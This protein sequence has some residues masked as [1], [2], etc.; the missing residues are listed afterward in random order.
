MLLPFNGLPRAEDN[1]LDHKRQTKEQAP[2]PEIIEPTFSD[3]S[4][5]SSSEDDYGQQQEG[6]I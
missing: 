4:S 1:E 2:M 6:Q 5:D 3:S